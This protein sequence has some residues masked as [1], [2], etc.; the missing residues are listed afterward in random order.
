MNEDSINIIVSN[1]Y[2]A[3]KRTIQQ[4]F[5]DMVKLYLEGQK[6]RFDK[7]GTLELEVR[8]GTK[9]IKRITHI[10]YD[11]VVK[12]LLSLGFTLAPSEYLLRITNEFID[13]RGI[14]KMSNIRAELRGLGQIADYCKNDSLTDSEGNTFATFEQKSLYKKDTESIYPIDFDDFNFRLALNVEKSYYE[15]SGI[16]RNTIEKWNDS[17]KVFRYIN[18]CTLTSNDYPVKVD[19]SITKMSKRRGRYPIPEYR[20]KDSGVLDSPQIYEIE[21]EVDKNKS[22]G[23]TNATLTKKLRNVIKIILSGLQNTNFPVSYPERDNVLQQYMKILWG[24]NHK[25]NGRVYP[26]NFVGPSSYT[27]QAN[28]VAPINP[29]AV[30]PNIRKDYTVTDKADGERKLLFI[31]ENGKIYLID[32][33]MNVQF[34][35]AITKINSIYSTIIDGEHILRNKSGDFINLYAAFDIYY[36]NSKDIRNLKF[37]SP[38]QEVDGDEEGETKEDV[39]TRLVLLSKVV[40]ESKIHSIIPNEK[41]PIRIEVKSFFQQSA[42]QSI[43]QASGFILKKEEDGLFEYNTDGVIFTP[44]YLSVGSSKQDEFVKPIKTTWDW[45]FKWKPPQENTI[46]FLISIKKTPDGQ[47]FIGNI[48]QKGVD[49]SASLQLTQFKTVILRVGYDEKKHGYINPCQSVIDD[50]MPNHNEKDNYEGYKPVQF[51]PTNPTDYEAGICNILL[52]PGPSDNMIMLTEESEVIEDNMIVEFRY[53]M[54]KEGPWRWVPVRVRYDKT[55]DLMEGGKNFG[56]AYHVANS[57]W[58]TIHNPIT[59]SMLSTGQNIPDELGDDDIYYNRI[60]GKQSGTRGLRDFHNLFVKKLLITRVSRRG[61]TLIDLAV[62]KGGDLPKWIN[63]NLKFVFG[64]DISR[65]NIQ[66]NLNGACARY[67]NYHKQFRVIPKALFVNG[68]SSV[69]IRNTD[70][71]LSE[72]GKQITK[73]VFGSGVKNSDELGKGVYNAYGIGSDGFDISSIQFAIHYMFEK[74]ETLF[75]FL[76]NVSETT[77][78]GGYFIGTSY[79]GMTIFDMLKRKSKGE[80]IVVMEGDEKLWEITKQYNKDEFPDNESSLGYG[81]DVYQESIN[82][83]FREYL[84]NYEYLTRMLENY[85][86]VLL[87]RQEIRDLN[88]PDSTGLFNDLFGIMKTE[89]KKSRRAVNEYGDAAKMTPGEKKISFLN[90]YFIYK[91][92]RNVD[93]D[94]I[95]LNLLGESIGEEEVAEIV[96]VV[97]ERVKKPK[98]I[99]K[100]LVLK[101]ND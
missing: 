12:R 23:E 9:G 75:N 30:I 61:D 94:T 95:T 72:K 77:K 90:R 82:K 89:M 16:I 62:G 18:R 41:S 44:S 74:P 36:I 80:S 11:N 25:E 27:L 37:T 39:N 92:V 56:N 32:T 96:E 79:D 48:F 47:D 69:N 71:I 87:T 86:F 5:D 10:D 19:L 54:S 57:N 63:A 3:S 13:P 29:D 101:S 73:A 88:L 78:V 2:M 17:K 50:D 45:S 55:A 53:D 42:S 35:G 6:N 84:V 91:K 38:P 33:N 83:V 52:K 51:Y 7:D 21:I 68:N 1:I 67:L 60:S 49:T 64:I 70:G 59:A 40:R 85:G 20:F 22:Y 8:F 28:N 34:T 98:K 76:R 14:T 4:Q 31:N 97:P 24:K 100:K 43:F 58:H 46:D 66:N 26:K 81:I 65:D 93:A 99:K 15:N